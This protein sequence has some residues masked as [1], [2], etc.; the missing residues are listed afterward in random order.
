MPFR[1]YSTG[2]HIHF[3]NIPYSS[4]LV[5]VLDNYLGLPLMMVE[6][7]RTASLRR[8]RYGFLG[9]VREKDYGGFEYR[10]PASFI[11]DKAVTAAALCIAYLIGIHHM[12]LAAADIYEPNLQTAFYQGNREALFPLVER[13][14]SVLRKLPM[15][16]RYREYIDPLSQMIQAR[17][18]WDESVDIRTEWGIPL[19][20]R[21]R[22][23]ARRGKSKTKNV[24]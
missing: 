19:E 17:E 3:S 5:K 7:K 23:Q 9:D 14:F 24:G 12:D 22:Q 4:H 15:Y 21:V 10:T 8:P 11:V 6:E 18:T 16:D 1:P 2:A 20:K 13:N